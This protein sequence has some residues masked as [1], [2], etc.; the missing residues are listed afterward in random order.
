MALVQMGFGWPSVSDVVGVI[1]APARVGLGVVSTVVK[2]GINT[3]GT[4]GGAATGAVVNTVSPLAR[5]AGQVA[6]TA[7]DVA[8]NLGQKINP[9]AP[10]LPP[11]PPPASSNLPIILGAG[12]AGLLL[13]A[14]LL[15]RPAA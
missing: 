9:A 14:V 6:S 10:P 1:T 13:V 2:T 7:L 11:L 12:A 5:G 15:R 8:A 3:V 4:I